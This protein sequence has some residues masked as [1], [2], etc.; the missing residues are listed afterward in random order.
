VIDVSALQPTLERLDLD[1]RPDQLLDLAVY[2]TLL[3]EGVD[4]A[5]LRDVLHDAPVLRDERRSDLLVHDSSEGRRVVLPDGRALLF[6]SAFDRNQRVT[7]GRLA[8]RVRAELGEVPQ[9]VELWR[10]VAYAGRGQILVE[11]VSELA[12]RALFSS[13]YGYHEARVTNAAE[14]GGFLATVDD[15]TFARREVGGVT[16]GGRRGISVTLAGRDLTHVRVGLD[17]VATLYRVHQEVGPRTAPILDAEELAP[18][19]R[20]AYNA[21]VEN[22]NAGVPGQHI[23]P[24]PFDENARIIAGSLHVDLPRAH[25]TLAE[26][27][28]TIRRV[29]PLLEAG[30]A[31]I[32]QG[33]N[34]AIAAIEA[35]HLLL[36]PGFS[37]DPKFRAP[38]VVAALDRV[39]ADPSGVAQEARARSH[40]LGP[41]DPTT[42]G[43]PTAAL[44]AR[45]LADSIPA[46]A[47]DQ[48]SRE[49]ARHLTRLRQ[50]RAEV[51]AGASDEDAVSR[52]V[53]AL[54]RDLNGRRTVVTPLVRY[55]VAREHVQCARYDGEAL[56]GSRVAATFFYCDVL[57]KLWG[58]LEYPGNPP[59]ASLVGFQSVTAQRTRLTSTDPSRR[60]TSTRLWFGPRPE[61]AARLPMWGG[62]LFDP[63]FTRLFAASSDPTR[64]GKEG[65]AEEPER[66]TVSWWNRNLQRIADFEPQY[67]RQN[68]LL[69]WSSAAAFMVRHHLL[70]DLASV[71]HRPVT[72]AQWMGQAGSSLRGARGI[73]VIDQ[74][75]WAGDTECLDVLA[76]RTQPVAGGS[77]WIEGGVNGAG[78]LTLRAMREPAREVP[79]AQRRAGTEAQ[80]GE[81]GVWRSPGRN[82]RIRFARASAEAETAEVS[83]LEDASREAVSA[84]GRPIRIDTEIR[85][86]SPDPAAPRTKRFELRQRD[87]HN[88]LLALAATRHPDGGVKFSLPEAE[89]VRAHPPTG[90]PI[91]SHAND[92][93]G[94]DRN[95]AEVMALAENG[96]SDGPPRDPPGALLAGFHE[97][98][99]GNPR[100]AKAHYERAVDQGVPEWAAAVFVRR[101]QQQGAEA[102]EYARIRLGHAHVP[103]ESQHRFSLVPYGPRLHVSF[104]LDPSVAR[105]QATPD[106]VF[107]QHRAARLGGA[108]EVYPEVLVDAASL[109]NRFDFVAHPVETVTNLHREHRVTI[110]AVPVGTTVG[111]ASFTLARDA[112]VYYIRVLGSAPVQPSAQ[113][114]IY[115]VSPSGGAN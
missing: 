74:A 13:E 110:S 45:H 17:D 109:A 90:P 112:R 35:Q 84:A 83:T 72:F 27:G 77:R 70:T 100:G 92:P 60:N 41:R 87:D 42:E 52:A 55:A 19:L 91:T 93:A 30:L 78:P 3:A 21:M 8:D 102:G 68:Q 76:S 20:R 57:A 56:R 82:L 88:Q 69:K 50:A 79:L 48:L 12:G 25:A 106:E 97:E 47:D 16:L 46:E 113:R 36:Q 54:E 9:R 66:R 114:V 51:A 5:T 63:W 15:L 103:A 111:T 11:R 67:H 89:D 62:I 22:H 95:F 73:E 2:G 1:E 32:E 96:G 24:G 61:A 31:R 64:R 86:F 105:R 99:R 18:T 6:V 26:Q 44:A 65:V 104:E 4:R 14:L 85:E 53:H 10:V 94:F 38:G 71:P 115:L 98:S 39:M 43:G 75:R 108:T 81:P 34:E 107:A 80:R 49:V 29:Q 37:L 58:S 101:M 28:E 59:V 40:A 23:V 7:F 33:A